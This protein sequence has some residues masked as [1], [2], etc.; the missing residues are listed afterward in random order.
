M[1]AL[2]PLKLAIGG[3]IAKNDLDNFIEKVLLH[4]AWI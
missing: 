2:K 4:L 3:R 1:A